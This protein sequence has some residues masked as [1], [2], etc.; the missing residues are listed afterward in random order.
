MNQTRIHHLFPVV[1]IFTDACL[2]HFMTISNKDENGENLRQSSERGD[3]ECVLQSHVGD[4]RGDA[5]ELF[6]VSPCRN[7]G[8]GVE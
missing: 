5:V 6:R 7:V 1:L 3:D 8:M 2:S 4:P